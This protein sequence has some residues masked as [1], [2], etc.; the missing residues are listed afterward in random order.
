[1]DPVT[2]GIDVAFQ[3]EPGAYSQ[4]AVRAL[5]PDAAAQPMHNLRKV[6]EAVEI[7]AVDYGVVPL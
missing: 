7:G 6:F 5:F 3:G 2:E 4:R 1:M